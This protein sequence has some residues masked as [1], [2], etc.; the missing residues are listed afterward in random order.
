MSSRSSL[1][2]LQQ[3]L[4]QLMAAS[5]TTGIQDGG[6]LE[7]VECNGRSPSRRVVKQQD[8][9]DPEV[10]YH[11]LVGEFAQEVEDA[12]KELLADPIFNYSSQANLGF[13]AF[14]A[15]THKR[16]L[17]VC[18]KQVTEETIFDISNNLVRLFCKGEALNLVDFSFATK[19]AVHFF[20][21]CGSLLLLGNDSHLKEYIPLAKTFD[22]RN[23]A[24]GC[25]AMTEK[26]HGSNVRA[27]ETEAR[28]DRSTEEFV[29]HSPTSNA[30][31]WFIGNAMNANFSVVFARLIID[32]TDH[33]PHAFIVRLR[34]SNLNLVHGVEIT[35][36][37][38]K[39]GL[40]GVD[41]GVIMFS[42]V[43]IPRANLLDRFAKVSADGVYSSEIKNDGKRFFKTIEALTPTRMIVTCGAI[44][45]MKIGLTVAIKYSVKRVQFG[46]PGGCEVPLME[47]TT[48]QSRLLPHV[49]AAYGFTFTLRDF[50]EM[51]MNDKTPENEREV[52]AL[53]AGLKALVCWEALDT[54][55]HCRECC[56]GQGYMSSNRLSWLRQDLDIFVTYEGD[57][58]VLLQ[59]VAKDLLDQYRK[60]FAQGMFT[61]M[62]AFLSQSTITAVK[63]KNP[64][65][66]SL[67]SDEHLLDPNFHS[68]CM[69]YMQRKLLHN[70]ARRLQGRIKSGTPPFT[71]WNECLRHTLLL[72]RVHVQ[73][74]VMDHFFQA[75]AKIPHAGTQTVMRDLYSLW[76]LGRLEEHSSWFLEHGYLS[77]VKVA[78]IRTLVLR[79]GVDLKHNAENLIEPWKIPD[80]LLYAPI[81]TQADFQTGKIHVARL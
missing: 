62:L 17:T 47:Y 40:N 54:L 13:E 34:D 8:G 73:R 52:I 9:F 51:Y 31:K 78:A 70:L 80:E 24:C 74:I 71:A 49:A 10:V 25:F 29:I 5:P 26:G 35:D 55:Q 63:E 4:Q 46:P 43:R 2:R 7:V 50:A 30:A 79:L 38:A 67:H 22:N 15:L 44:S 19:M 1:T 81:A 27:L 16:C 65:V 37:G 68:N 75:V 72:A 23:G 18:E 66:L 28:Y 41:N 48:H 58:T 60:Q 57:N 56:G 59:Q 61:G 42:N 32:D 39:M 77:K 12:K 76:A 36:C 21:F 6:Q 64:Y 11:Y 3:L 45:A 14:R 33:G 20:L 53:V 69:A